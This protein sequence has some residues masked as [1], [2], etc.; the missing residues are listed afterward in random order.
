MTYLEE[1]KANL[2]KEHAAKQQ[3]FD[4]QEQK[5]VATWQHAMTPLDQRLKILLDDMPE[6]IKTSGVIAC[7]HVATAF[8]SCSSNCCC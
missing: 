3:Q 6:L 5:A 4:E 1:L 7:C 8:C 2:A